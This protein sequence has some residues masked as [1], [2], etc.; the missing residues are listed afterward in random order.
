MLNIIFKVLL[1]VGSLLCLHASWLPAKAWLSQELINY[2]WQQS[3]A[4]QTS[5][6]KGAS[7]KH[8]NQHE[9]NDVAIKPWPWA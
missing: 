7:I 4:Q 1:I 2:S 5:V 9:S 6:K 8:E 3:M